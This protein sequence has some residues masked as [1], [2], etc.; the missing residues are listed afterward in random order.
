MSSV[1]LHHYAF[2][3]LG[4]NVPFDQPDYSGKL[5]LNGTCFSVKNGIFLTAAHVLKGA[6]SAKFHAVYIWGGTS[7][8]A[9]Y[10]D[11]YEFFEDY[12]LAVFRTIIEPSIN[13]EEFSWRD[14]TLSSAAFVSAV[15]YAHGLDIEQNS[16]SLRSFSGFIVSAPTY[17]KQV[18]SRARAYELSFV[19]PLDLSGAP[20]L[21]N[22]N[23]HGY[24]I[25][26][27]E[28]KIL[29]NKYETIEKDNEE[30]RR[31]TEEY[32]YTY[33]SIAIRTEAILALSSRILQA[34]LGD[35]LA[36]NNLLI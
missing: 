20:L 7:F 30:V 33:F 29:I 32:N 8:I 35:Y 23:I 3:V 36:R 18:K 2:P 28:S 22:L 11:D 31:V 21:N 27:S 13:V 25:G 34:T 5:V 12:D 26:M 15:G 19:S 24:I 14:N 10:F 6:L 4:C 16:L 9:Y 1:D 17:C